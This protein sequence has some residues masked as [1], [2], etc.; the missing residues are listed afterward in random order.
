MALLQHMKSNDNN[1][2]EPPPLVLVPI[3]DIEKYGLSKDYIL[4]G[5]VALRVGFTALLI[6]LSNAIY[7]GNIALMFNGRALVSIF[8]GI[9]G[10]FIYYI[11]LKRV[12]K[13]QDPE[14]G[15]IINY[16]RIEDI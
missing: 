7:D 3:I 5:S 16:L 6:H 2:L 15:D 8:A 4:A 1:V 14:K 12:I 11:L 9:I 13:F 10:S